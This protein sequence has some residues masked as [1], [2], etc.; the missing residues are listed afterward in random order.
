MHVVLSG[1]IK[2]CVLICMYISVK[3]DFSYTDSV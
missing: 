1:L 3:P 2:V